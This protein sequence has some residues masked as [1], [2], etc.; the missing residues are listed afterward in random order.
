MSILADFPFALA[1]AMELPA[2]PASA[3]KHNALV[4]FPAN[5]AENVH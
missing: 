3:V 5:G 2:L 4:E 1:P